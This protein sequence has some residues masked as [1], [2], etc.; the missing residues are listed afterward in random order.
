MSE[1]PPTPVARPA[2]AA[3]IFERDLTLHQVGEAIGCS[4][5]QVRRICLPFDHPNRRIPDV[6]RM[7]AIVRFTAG[8]ITV[9]SFYPP[10]ARGQGVKAEAF[11]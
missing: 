5:E 7:T 8:E 2:F 1:K 9:E 3:W 6:E 10:E 11:A 4:A